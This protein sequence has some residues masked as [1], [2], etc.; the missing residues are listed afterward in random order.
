MLPRG[1]EEERVLKEKGGTRVAVA[2]AAQGGATVVVKTVAPETPERIRNLFLDDVRLRTDLA[3]RGIAPI[4]ESG[5]IAD[6][7]LYA[8]SPF[9]EGTDPRRWM[10]RAPNVRTAPFV[11]RL[12]EP[13]AFLHERGQVHGDIKPGNLLFR[14]DGEE[15][16]DLCWTDLLPLAFRREGTFGILVGTPAYLAPEA[17]RGDD[18]DHRADL[19]ALGA[20]LYEILAGRPL[21]EGSA[22]DLARAHLTTDARRLLPAASPFPDLLWKAIA[23]LLE[24]EPSDRP[25]SIE[26]FLA[27]AGLGRKR[28]TAALA[29]VAPNVRRKD[30]E[31]RVRAWL[32]EDERPSLVIAGDPG[33]GRTRFLRRLVGELRI[34]GRP[35]VAA[36]GTESGEAH[37]FAGV[38]KLFAA[39]SG[40]SLAL[41]PLAPARRGDAGLSPLA[42]GARE[43][44]RLF[45][46]LRALFEEDLR[47]LSR[48]G[49]PPVLVVIDDA[50]RLDEISSR[51]LLFLIERGRALPAR[52]L[53]AREAGSEP[54]PLFAGLEPGRLARIERTDPFTHEEIAAWIEG[55]FGGGAIAPDLLEAA[56]R[57]SEG[58]PARLEALVR[59]WAARG[60]IRKRRG[61]LH[62]HGSPPAPSAVQAERARRI[63]VEGLSVGSR[64]LAGAIAL[65]AGPR[66]ARFFERLLSIRP[67][68]FPML[69]A[70]LLERRLVRR[71][72]APAGDAYAPFS[73][74]LRERLAALLPAG[75]RRVLHRAAA[76]LAETSAG[77]AGPAAHFDAAHHWERAG[78]R[79]GAARALLRAAAGMEELSL[80][81]EAGDLYRM[82]LRSKDGL[83]AP[84]ERARILLALASLRHRDGRPRAALAALRLLRRT[85]AKDEEGRGID[86]TARRLA[87]WIRYFRGNA[88][89]AEKAL[90]RLLDEGAPFG[91]GEEAAIRCD[92]GWFALS[93]GDAEAARAHLGRAH[94]STKRSK[95]SALN[96]RTLK[97]LGAVAFYES[98][99]REAGAHYERAARILE[100]AA[101][102]EAVGAFANLGLVRLWTG[103][104]AEAAALLENA[105]SLARK[106]GEVLEEARV[107]EDL[108]RVLFRLGRVEEAARAWDEAFS[109]YEDFGDEGGKVRVLLTRGQTARERGRLDQSI[110]LLRRGLAL[111]RAGSNPYAVFDALNLAAL[112]HI[113]R[114]E[115]KE[116][117]EALREAEAVLGERLSG[118]YEAL[119]DRTKARL[120]FLDGRPA[121][122]EKG[123]VRAIRLFSK[124]GER[125][126]E[127]ETILLAAEARLHAGGRGSPA[128]LLQKAERLSA[129]TECPWI[130]CRLNLL[131]G[132]HEEARGDPATARSCLR[133]AIRSAR[134][135]DARLD[136]A[137]ALAYLAALEARGGERRKAKAHADEAAALYDLMRAVSPPA[138]LGEARG[139]VQGGGDEGGEGLR[140]ICRIARIINSLRASDAV[141]EHVLD[142]ALDHL[143]G[144]RGLIL[145]YGADGDLVPRA[146]RSIEG[147]DL[148]DVTRFSRTLFR[149]AEESEEPLVAENALSDPRFEGAESVAAYNILSFACAPLRSK[150]K[151]IGLVYL[152]NC[153]S[154]NV[155]TPRDLSFLQA[156]ADLA[157]VALENARLLEDLERENALLREEA[158]RR[159]EVPE[160]IA[161]SPAMQRTLRELRAAARSDIAVLLL[162]ET[163]AGKGLAAHLIHQ[164]SRRRDRPFLRL[165]CSAIAPTLVEDELFG[166]E[167]GAFTDARERKAGIFERANRG[168]LLLDEIGD[169]P[170][171]SQVKLLRVLQEGEFER[172]GG[173]E[174]IRSDVRILA[175]TNRNLALLAERG[176]FR[177]DLFYR[178]NGVAIEIPPLRAR[179]E[180][181]PA[182]ARTFLAVHARRNRKEIRSIARAAESLLIAYGWP[183]NV[184]ELDHVIERAV[185]FCDGPRIETAHLTEEVRAA[186]PSGPAPLEGSE[187]NMKDLP[188][189]IRS[190]EEEMLLRALEESG[191]NRSRAARLLGIHESTVRKKIRRLRLKRT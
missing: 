139:L 1:Y 23:R 14:A 150:G 108:G 188:G 167:P 51:F 73:E 180:D 143:R 114:E 121:E 25:S 12:A 112:T 165:N 155:F 60:T 99:W 5:R 186:F 137:E 113:A 64:E 178:L 189:E 57:F 182:L 111:A 43:E 31:A 145:L 130:A 161:E 81:R 106:T 30:L 7:S 33:S 117:E 44:T 136:L 115:P 118:R 95:T 122:A 74:S 190:I 109:I 171:A 87:A 146:S 21:F 24:K 10:L 71:E 77:D 32:A 147:E 20:T 184:R 52:Y 174:T 134:A 123:L 11:K 18:P 76:R 65:P 135:L 47:R 177:S 9:V 144:E 89:E 67:H 169:M 35:V 126:M 56:T 72:Q 191:W 19:Y 70:P 187:E 133:D 22:A 163:G 66:E 29:P 4:L 176:E 142:Q 59:E 104:L 2:R 160:I 173:T 91:A 34:E 28:K 127:A 170:I 49:S 55:A 92:L 140:T 100:R 105:L 61:T 159:A 97:R 53:L 48:D 16:L 166:H 131:Y 46:K 175:A 185:V 75:R 154:A 38:E 183:G 152:D 45:R 168:T 93:R 42:A 84:N 141:L 124:R 50:D 162:G 156:L 8:V 110:E 158:A 116:A 15:I 69:A 151:P 128:A 164:E 13:I 86:R 96:G 41:G 138:A 62:L 181:I 54:G 88:K 36:A 120:A 80:V 37:P 102:A 78:N 68:D 85:A 26:E 79:A 157:G 98:A 119:L 40:R 39:L 179:R 90:G 83:R 63:P 129:R 103:R 94:Q 3:H 153:R 6:G 149:K 17:I 58:N 132:R 107:L 101:P 125:L 82:A 27:E 172:L 148:R